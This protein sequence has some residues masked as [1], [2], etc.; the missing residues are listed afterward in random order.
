M[1]RQPGISRMTQSG[2]C[3][4]HCGDDMACARAHVVGRRAQTAAERVHAPLSRTVERVL[5]P[6]PLL[7]HVL[8]VLLLLLLRRLDLHVVAAQQG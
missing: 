6:P 1:A 4:G 5:L 3:R 2:H 7:R 8:P